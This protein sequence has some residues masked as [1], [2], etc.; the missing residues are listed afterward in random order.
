MM[1]KWFVAAKK[2]DFNAW[3]KKLNISPVT[4]RIIRNRDIFSEEEAEK[5]V[6]GTFL[7]MYPPELMVDMEEAAAIIERKIRSGEKLRVIGDYDVDGIMASHILTKGL[8]ALSAEVDTVIPHR[9]R[10]GY[11]LNEQLIADAFTDGINTIITCDNGIAAAPQIA[12]A[13]SKNMTVV[14]TDHHE[15]PY[16]EENGQRVELLPPA[17]AVVDPK[18]EDCT[19]PYKNICGA[20]VAYKLISLLLRRAGMKP[21]QKQ[22]LL[23]E[24]LQL[25]A[26]ATVCDV[27]ELLDE[28]RI[29]VKEGLQ[30]M[31]R[32]PCEGI[33]AL[34]AVNG[35]EQEKLS[36]YHLG[37]VIGPCLNATGRLDTAARALALLSA[38]DRRTAVQAAEELKEMNDSRK[39]MT[40]KGLEKAVAYVEEN[41]IAQDKVL[42]VYLPDCHESLA[43]IVAGRL[44]EKYGRPVFVL[45]RAEDGVK[46]SGRSVEGYDMYA[47]M[48]ACKTL[49]T[50]FGGHKMAA[51]LSMREEDIPALRKQLNE[52]CSLTEEDFI[53]K[54]HI[55]VP[56]PLAYADKKLAEELQILEPF[57][58]ANPKPL[59]AC[60]EVHFLAGKKMGAKENFARYRVEHEGKGY[61]VVYFGGL[62]KFHAFLTEK[63]G[64]GAEEALYRGG[65]DYC[66]SITYQLGINSYRGRSEVQILMQHFC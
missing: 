3:S 34:L 23:D 30:R 40:F 53:E 60:K 42:V 62:E 12:L 17:A 21:E 24:F 46:G 35:I 51:G 31:Q 58:T 63:F 66:L 20:V 48:T 45:T 47:S 11:G 9:V 7:D 26:V 43:G 61:E 65:C 33:R 37:F 56:L 6:N 4:A 44:R 1:E 54:V 8:R 27:M 59:F 32:C 18:R 16:T 22:G 25:A 39:L 29:I 57:G 14:V 38:D 49:F 36:A 64:E 50:K 15:V 52:T 41:A 2:A 13:V 55:D 28:N 5:Y 19:Y 10:D